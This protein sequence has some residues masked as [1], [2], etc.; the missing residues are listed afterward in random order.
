MGALALHGCADLEDYDKTVSAVSHSG[1]WGIP[2]D[3]L[4]IGDEQDVVYTG[5]GP[6]VGE[7]GCGPG[8]TEGARVL[9][10]W[11][12]ASWPQI[13][14]IGGYNCRPIVGDSANMSVHATGRALDVMIP[15]YAGDADNDLG[16]PI[17]AWLIE[18]SEEIGIQL[19]IWDRWSWGPH[20]PDGQKGRA[21]TGANPHID[22]L[23]VELSVEASML[24]TPWFSGPMEPPAVAD[25]E[26]IAA[27]GGEMEE[28]SRCVA[29]Y[30]PAQYW[31]SE[32]VGHGGALRWT[33]AYR[34]A[35]PSNWARWQLRLEEAGDYQVEVYIEP[36]FG[37]Y[38]SARYMVSHAGEEHELTVD[39]SSAS[40]WTSLGSFTFAAGGGQHLNVYDNST[41]DVPADQHIPVDAIRLTPVTEPIDPGHSV[42]SLDVVET[43]APIHVGDPTLDDDPITPPGRTS[44]GGCAVS[45][46]GS[47]PQEM[48]WL[49]A[50]GLLAMRIRRR[51]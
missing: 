46:A 44:A 42:R 36:G 32:S 49:V 51:R 20:R 6:W 21:Y 47:I 31:R 1:P 14:S 40:G 16:D 34:G 3:T 15:T 29:L 38:D 4:A 11:M 24:G 12:M 30:G 37:V 25:C 28:T 26:M 27:V 17:G 45:P 8:L 7:S 5:A 18:H 39:L 50:V 22:H 9:R 23:H 2:A 35:S 19:I 13:A 48:L 33:N 43:H 41:V 10:T